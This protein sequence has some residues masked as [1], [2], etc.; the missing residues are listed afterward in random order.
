MQSLSQNDPLGND[1]TAVNRQVLE[2]IA[3]YGSTDPEDVCL[4]LNISFTFL[5]TVQ[6][7]SNEKLRE[8]ANLGQ[9]LLQPAIEP[10]SLENCAKL[11]HEQAKTHLRSVTRLKRH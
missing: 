6:N 9:F 5:K 3:R 7:L 1:I 10:V 11:T 8:I 4:R 2:L